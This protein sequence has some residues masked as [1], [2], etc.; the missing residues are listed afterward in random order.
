M[1]KFVLKPFKPAASLDQAGAVEVWVSLRQA[2]DKIHSQ[3]L[4]QLSFEE[5][6]R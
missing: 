5:L 3:E 4:S 2:I 1:K 6:Y